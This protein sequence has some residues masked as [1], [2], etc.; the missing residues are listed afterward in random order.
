M[1]VDDNVMQ[2]DYQARFG[3]FHS[4]APTEA[5]RPIQKAR[6]PNPPPMDCRTEQKL[7]YKHFKAEKLKPCKVSL[8]FHSA[9][10]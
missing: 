9:I 8:V 7:A 5:I 2:T 10:Y 6:N 1:N 4:I 3:E